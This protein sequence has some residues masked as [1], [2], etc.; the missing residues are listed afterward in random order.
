M[1][2]AFAAIPLPDET[3]AA[4]GLA[5]AALPL[6][7][8]VP[9]ENLHLTL[10]FLGELPEPL[11]EE[12]HFAFS[13][14]HAAGFDL[15]LQGLGMFGTHPPRSVHAGVVENAALRHLQAKL[16]QAARGAGAR[17][18]RRRFTPHVTLAYLNPRTTDLPRLERALAGG[19]GFRAG[20][21]PVTGFTLFRSDLSRGGARHTELARYPLSA[22]SWPAS[23]P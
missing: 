22:S 17:V 23:G 4:L 12:V 9:P 20:P 14:V 18:E 15:T 5:Q 7:R 11:L 1:I 8:P 13:A 6:A 19:A 10:A 3:R 16:E 21:F 2:R